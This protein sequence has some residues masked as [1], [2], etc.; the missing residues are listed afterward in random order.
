MV[1]LYLH[2]LNNNQMF[3]QKLYSFKNID[4]DF[5]QSNPFE[6]LQQVE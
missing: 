6:I 4:V 5:K 2:C 1:A 3:E